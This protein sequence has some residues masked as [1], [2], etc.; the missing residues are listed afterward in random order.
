MRSMAEEV[1]EE[2]VR[3]KEDLEF[4]AG[5]SE[6]LSKLRSQEADNTL[7]ES[8]RPK[9]DNIAEDEEVRSKTTHERCSKK[10]RLH[11]VTLWFR[12]GFPG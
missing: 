2:E 5:A 6:R 10:S 9:L 8:Q 7:T 12:I 4:T 11:V 3:R 1:K